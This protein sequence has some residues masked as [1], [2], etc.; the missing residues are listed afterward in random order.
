MTRKVNIHEAKTHFSKLI[1]AVESGEE[2]I[3]A[4]SGKP[5]VKLVRIEEPQV[6]IKP[7]FARAELAEWADIDW[8]KLDKRFNQLFKDN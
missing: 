1:E 8:V 5:V 4:R 7:G 6:D 2:V 3:V